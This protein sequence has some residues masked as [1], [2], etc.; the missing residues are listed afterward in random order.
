MVDLCLLGCGGGMPMPF[1]SLSATLLNFK[2]RKILIDCGEGTQV[3]MRMVGWGFKSIDMICITHCHG[4]HIIGLPGILS[5]IGNSGR[6][7]PLTIIGPEGINEAV[8]GLM[9]ITK[10][11]PYEV[12]IIENPREINL[13]VSNENIEVIEKEGQAKI[14]TLELDHSS[15]CLGYSFY[16]KRERKFSLEKALENNVPKI[17]WNKLQK[18]NEEIILYEGKE[19]KK[20]MVLGEKRRGI[21][22]SLITDSRPLETMINFIEKSDLLICEGTYG[23]NDDIDK[24]IKN[25][26]MTFKEAAS[27]ARDS[28]CKE[29]LLT[30]FTPAMIDP[31]MYESN[32]KDIFENTIIGEDRLVKN[33]S[34]SSK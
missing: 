8:N 19:Y 18:G 6:I 12:K 16:F 11:L 2:G 33:I 14:S 27:L 7:E 31:K 29:L 1:R 21:K 4:D 23:S 22:V 28:N 26:H 25:K 30:H 34:Y 32:A 3:S 20:E 5:T 9:V 13:S 24:A 15:S 10:Y 17:L